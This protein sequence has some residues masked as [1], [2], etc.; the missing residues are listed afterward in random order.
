MHPGL[1]FALTLLLAIT[2]LPLTAAAAGAATFT[3]DSTLDA[4]ADPGPPNNGCEAAGGDECTLREAILAGNASVGQDDV[5]FSVAGTIQPA[6]P[7]LP[8]M[9]EFDTQIE[10][11]TA[12]GYAAGAPVIEIDGS[13]AGVGADG[14]TFAGIGGE[15]DALVIN[16]FNDDGVQISD[17]AAGVK[18]SFI[19][20]DLTG[21]IDRGNGSFGVE[22]TD[23]GALVG[24][25]TAGD[26]NVISGND[27]GGVRFD[28]PTNQ[29]SGGQ[30]LG[31]LI[32]TDVTGTQPLGNTLMGVESAVNP[33]NGDVT[34]GG[35]SPDEEN[36][37]AYNGSSGGVVVTGRTHVHAN[38]IFA[39]GTLGVDLIGDGVTPNDPNDT[40]AGP[41]NLL[42][43]P[44][45]DAAVKNGTDLLVTGTID[46]SVST[47]P[48][49][50]TWFFANETCDSSG[51]GEGERFLGTA[52]ASQ[53]PGQPGDYNFAATLP[54]GSVDAGDELTAIA[55]EATVGTSEFSTCFEAGG[56][57]DV[58][59]SVVAGE[60]SGT[61]LYK[62]PGSDEFVELDEQST[63]PEGTIV[64]ATNGEVR[65]VSEA[66][67]E[68]GGLREA[69]M[70]QGR[71]K[72]LQDDADPFTLE[73]RLNGGTRCGPPAKRAG[74]RKRQLEILTKGGRHRSRGRH[75]A[76]TVRGTNWLTKDMCK[77]TFFEVF[78]GS[79]DVEDFVKDKIVEL[80]AGETYLAKKKRRN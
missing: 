54:G 26:G 36:V 30:I 28:D 45:F 35:F 17:G 58:G 43:T 52:L 57:P 14:I 74:G 15:V 53:V 20:T 4:V 69:I 75:G 48:P 19:G 12:P 71:F 49:V 55:E 44:V 62:A 29:L 66:P 39:N 56:P 33:A 50:R 11:D 42:N 22:V 1:R 8:A 76:G 59:A 18:R 67:T 7:G 61:I 37:I 6:A 38:R 79:V 72:V 2:A 65:I 3:V 5:A 70:S 68:P 31:N 80:E 23:A 40:D 77:G 32:G 25:P 63:L 10:G 16:R 78:E 21:T 64:D 24:G 41:N 60:V 34:V 9:T 47:A 51:S 13:L 27:I 46:L 73:A